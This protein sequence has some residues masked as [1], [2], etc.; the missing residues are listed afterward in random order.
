MPSR[1]QVLIHL[2]DTGR[3][4][5]SELLIIRHAM[6]LLPSIND[7]AWIPKHVDHPCKLPAV[8]G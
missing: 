8:L 5:E 4:S 2:L 7:A 6:Q 1:I 3:L